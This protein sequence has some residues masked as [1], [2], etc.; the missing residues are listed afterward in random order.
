MPY[1]H[2]HRRIKKRLPITSFSNVP[3]TVAE[4]SGWALALD[5]EM[6]VLS[7]KLTGQRKRSWELCFSS[8]ELNT[9]DS[10]DCITLIAPS[11]HLYENLKEL[12]G[13]VLQV[14]KN[15]HVR[16][17]QEVEYLQRLWRAEQ[18]VLF[19]E[20]VDSCVE[21]VVTSPKCTAHQKLIALRCPSDT[22]T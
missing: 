6:N 7:R 13:S 14:K 19:K 21:K 18:H 11:H 8:Q 20:A 9:D 3:K 15:Y 4:H 12:Y 16:C 10:V 17:K 1:E 2:N 22:L 5:L